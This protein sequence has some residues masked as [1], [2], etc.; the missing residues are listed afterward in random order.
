MNRLLLIAAASLL[1][2]RPIHA[3]DTPGG[4]PFGIT[5]T[6][7]ADS[8]MMLASF[9]PAGEEPT[10]IHSPALCEDGMVDR[11]PGLSFRDLFLAEEFGRHRDGPGLLTSSRF[12]SE[13][14]AMEQSYESFRS[15]HWRDQG[16][17]L[18]GGQDSNAVKTTPAPRS[19]LL[20]EKLSFFERGMWGEDGFLRNIGI[21]SPLTPEVR[22]G[23][24]SVRRT[25]LT[26]HQI[27][28]FVTLGLM[29]ATVFYGQRYLDHGQKS[30]GNMHQL[31]VAATI[32]SYSATA[33]LS[34]FSPPPLIRRDETSTT[35]IH[36]T[37]A[38]VHFAGMVVTPILGAVIKKRGGSYYQ[39]AHLH[40][41][42]AYI[43]TAVFTAAMVVM[44]F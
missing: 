4:G 26:M 40:Q 11:G 6:S 20:P 15:V 7:E 34:V 16:S 36:K 33:L 42:S 13:Q 24:L 9:E 1:A 44:T 31:F 14:I 25:M 23:E 27:G 21:A 18:S 35:T 29:G 17:E 38:W 28:G 39:Q 41:V 30:D 2:S 32:T 22:K 43:T 10:A 12:F 8:S 3:Q 5:E 19:R 37:L